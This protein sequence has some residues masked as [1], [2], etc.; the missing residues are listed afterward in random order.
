MKMEGT[1]KRRW[2]VW[3]GAAALIGAALALTGCDGLP[4]H[5]A[6]RTVTG[7]FA[8]TG[9]VDLDVWTTNGRVTVK[10]VEGLTTV[11][12]TATVRSR[13]DS[14]IDAA[15]RAAQVVVEMGHT[16]NHIELEYD[17]SAHP[18]DVRRYTG[19]DFEVTVPTTVDIEVD[20]SNGRVTVSDVTG[21]L[22]LS[23]SNGAIEVTTVVGETTASTSNGAIRIE[24][25]EGVLRLDTSNGR[26]EM[27]EAAGAVDARASNGAITFAGTLIEGVEHRM[28][29]SNGR[30]DVTV[31]SDASL[32]I[33]A[34]TSNA[35]ISTNLPL[36]GDIEGKS[37]SA[38]LNPPATATLTLDTSNGA[39]EILGSP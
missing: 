9:A 25:Y 23:T 20:T 22:D 36:I 31:P 7:S 19:V 18:W 24:A 1:M 14:L 29:T 11:E 35:T 17:A 4:I 21:I 34:R 16:G 38:V 6:V 27:T 32:Q 39:I 8:V 10:G 26:I 2:M 30:I 3:A 13:G 15:A 33:D 28:R 12:V 37:W 5:E